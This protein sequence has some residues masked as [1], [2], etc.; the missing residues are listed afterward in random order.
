MIENYLDTSPQI[1]ASSWV[2]RSAVVI[3]NVVLGEN[4]SVWPCAVIRGDV[5]LIQIGDNSNIQDGSVIHATH[6]G[7][8]NP[9]GYPTHIGQSVTIGHNVIVH[10]AT[11]GDFVLIGM[12]STILDGSVIESEVIIGAGSLVP[13]NKTLKS[14]YLY[15]GSPAKPV[16]ELTA[17]EKRFLRYS[18][19]HYVQLKNA[20][21][22]GGDTLT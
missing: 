16:R 7:E 3:G 20:H 18:A 12:G 2:H 11:I 10:G 1:G 21:Q 4:V 22:Q 6:A 13:M 5:N 19:S 14:G 8:F 17:D 9:N 15:L